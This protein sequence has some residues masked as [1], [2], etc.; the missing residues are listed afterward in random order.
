MMGTIKKIANYATN[1]FYKICEH[2]DKEHRADA[3]A[4]L[5][6]LEARKLMQRLPTCSHLST[7][8]PT[9]LTDLLE[10]A[11]ETQFPQLYKK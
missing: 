1:I 11:L 5:D 3:N 9:E 10:N 2:L 7:T 6:A 8:N 4:Y